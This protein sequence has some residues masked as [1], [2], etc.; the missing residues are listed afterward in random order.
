MG[1]QHQGMNRPGV[2]HIPE[3]SGERGKME[4]TG[5]KIICGAQTTL[6]VKGLMMMMMMKALRAFEDR[7]LKITII[8]VIIIKNH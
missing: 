8:I 5:Y 3:G 7:H 6:T 2:R 1:R 4:K